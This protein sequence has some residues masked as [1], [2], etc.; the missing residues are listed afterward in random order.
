M[1]IVKAIPGLRRVLRVKKKI[2]IRV[3]TAIITPPTQK[4]L[5]TY[6]AVMCGEL[7]IMAKAA[8]LPFVC[9]LLAMSEAEALY[10]AES[11]V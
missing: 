1:T 5:A 10:V 8:N 11:I 6:L 2:P 4:E 3:L 9:H 7:A